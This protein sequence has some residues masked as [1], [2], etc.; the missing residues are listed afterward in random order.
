MPRPGALAG[1]IDPFAA[2]QVAMHFSLNDGA[3]FY[4]EAIKS[5]FKWTVAPTPKGKDKRFQFVG[6]SAF[7]IPKTAK[8]ADIA[9]QCI[10]FTA[11]DPANLPITGEMGSMFVSN[12]KYWDK[13]APPKD[14]LDTTAFKHAFYDVALKDGIAPNY[15]PQYQQW[16]TSVY[17]KNMS[18]LWTGETTDVKATLQQVQ[19]ETKALLST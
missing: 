19:T 3:L 1:D 10:K 4:G 7:S 5:K 14:M 15:F 9:Y 13:A 2:G 12:S 16:D 8:F 17:E 6:G 18:R 11:T